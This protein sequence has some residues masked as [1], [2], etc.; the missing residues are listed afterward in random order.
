VDD[1]LLNVDDG[2]ATITLNRPEALNAFTDAMEAGLL[3][4]LDR[5]D[6]DDEVR[7]VILTGAGRAFCAGM[8]LSD[9]EAT[10]EAW[11]SSANAPPATQ[12][13]VGEAYPLRRDGG[14]RVALRLFELDKPVIAAINGHAVGVGATITLPADVRIVADH[15]RI[16]F[17]FT[18]RG[19]VPE[20]C[21]SWFLPRVVPVQTALEWMLTGRLVPAAEALER[22][23]AR[24]IHPAEEVVAVARALA[25]EIADNTAPVS[26]TVARRAIWAML[27]APHPMAAHEFETLALNSRGLSADAT[28]GITAFLDKRSPDFPDRVPRD[29]PEVLRTLP[30]PEYRPTTGA[31]R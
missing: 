6:H 2:I 24:S 10:F 20:S 28:E 12:F 11:R 25:R 14:G 23:L 8:D 17:V 22:G 5:C 16:G 18:R 30:A 31:P 15:A 3:E 7:V 26:V 1:V 21:S 13:D 9:S 27:G 4:A 29:V 19:L